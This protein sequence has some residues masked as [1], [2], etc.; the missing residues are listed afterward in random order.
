MGAKLQLEQVQTLYQ[1]CHQDL[2]DPVR[3]RIHRSF[4]WLE[5]AQASSDD[6]MQ[7]MCL[8]VA[9]NAAYARDLQHYDR[10]AESV[11]FRD[12]L[13]KICRFQPEALQHLIWD[14]YPNGIRQLLD[15]QF[16]FQPFWDFH[17]GLKTEAAWQNEFQY[18]KRKSLNAW[19]N[20]DT[21]VVLM[22]VFE[23]IYTL[24][25]QIFHG[26]ATCGSSVNRQQLKSALGILTDTIPV[27]LHVM[28]MHPNE[29]VWGKPYYPL[30]KD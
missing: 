8:W 17:N 15:N 4:S 23:R 25:N 19:K 10:G 14:I 6:D 26:G 1:S 7:F 3:L 22:V 11:V 5:Q 28:L 9:F 30:V 16:A 24:R 18:A 2:P 20:K 13:Q 21:D 27:F 29:A 12:F